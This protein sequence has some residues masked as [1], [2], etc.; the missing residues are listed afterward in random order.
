MQSFL[1]VF[2]VHDR[3]V[4]T[5]SC[6][7]IKT[8]H[9]FQLLEAFHYAIT[10]VNDKTG[11]FAGILK[12]I[13]LGGVGLDACESTIKTGYTV[14][15]IHNGIIKLN[16]NGENIAPDDISAYIA[17]YSSDSSLYLARILKSLKIPQISYASTSIALSDQNKYPYFMRSVPSDNKQAESMIKFLDN[18]DIRYVQVVYSPTNYGRLG[19]MAFE[20]LARERKICIGQM[21]Q[22]PDSG[23]VT[24][25]SFNEVISVLL[26]KPTANTVVLFAG[27]GYINALFQA[28][29]RNPSAIAKY[30]FLGTETW[31][32]NLDVLS[33]VEDLAK[34]AV[35]WSLE[36]TDIGDF[37][38][39]L[40]TKSPGNYPQNPWFPQ[41]YE[42]MVDCYLTVPDGRHSVQCASL[43]EVV[44][45]QRNY[46]QDQGILHVINAVYAAAIGIDSALKLVCGVDYSTVCEKFR[47]DANRRDILMDNILKSNFTDPTGYEFSFTD[48][49][50]GN[51]GYQMY[52]LSTRMEGDKLA[53]YYKKV[54]T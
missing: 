17:G 8:L 31:G 30:F 12:N 22:L 25:E 19:S 49:R 9:G 29:R 35:T 53:Y 6:G 24:R 45:S 2:D 3:D 5:F 16:K 51:K 11:P 33:G 21:I 38:T 15:N 18:F 43:S 36:S 46:I 13:K 28:I 48:Q 37:D 26:K 27:T 7:N 20:N 41:F 23:T 40:G 10:K 39:Y 42:E 34:N 14:S 52:S 4:T 1:G 32:N 44:I 54:S 50:D 47:N